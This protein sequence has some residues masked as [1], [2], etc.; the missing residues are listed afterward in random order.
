MIGL[1]LMLGTIVYLCIIIA[2]AIWLKK[3]HCD[4][5]QRL[6]MDIESDSTTAARIRKG[7]EPEQM[8]NDPEGKDKKNNNPASATHPSKPQ[9]EDR[10]QGENGNEVSD[11]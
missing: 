11:D 4:K 8:A 5:L 1:P 2:L 10:F 7:V 9:S 3:Y 6:G